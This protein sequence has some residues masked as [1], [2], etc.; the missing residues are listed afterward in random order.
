MSLYFMSPQFN[1]AAIYCDNKY[2]NTTNCVIICY[3]LS[4]G[5]AP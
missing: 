3:V 4:T 5:V 1:K 2:F